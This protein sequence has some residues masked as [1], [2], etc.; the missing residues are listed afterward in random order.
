MKKT[1]IVVIVELKNNNIGRHII[2]FRWNFKFFIVH[3][4]PLIYSFIS[5]SF[6]DIRLSENP[7]ADPMRGGIPRY[8]LIARLSKV[9][10][11]NGS[12]VVWKHLKPFSFLIITLLLTGRLLS[13]ILGNSSWKKRLWNTVR[14][15]IF[16]V[17]V[18]FFIL[19]AL[20]VSSPLF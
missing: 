7:I 18:Y 19:F 20:L 6:K 3:F 10:I 16:W 2:E 14:K 9:Q 12:E 11:I 1:K 13:H 15:T 8:V 4:S 17:L 5:F